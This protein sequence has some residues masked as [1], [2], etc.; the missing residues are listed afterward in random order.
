MVGTSVNCRT[1]SNSCPSQ[2]NQL[3]TVLYIHLQRLV[4]REVCKLATFFLT[5]V[6]LNKLICHAHLSFSANQFTWPRLLVQIQ[7]LNGKQCRSRSVGFFRSQLIWIC[8]VC[9]G[10]VYLGSAGQG[11][12]EKSIIIFHTSRKIMF[13]SH[14][15]CLS[16]AILIWRNKKVFIWLPYRQ[17]RGWGWGG[18][19]GVWV[20]G[21]CVWGGGGGESRYEISIFL[22]SP[23]KHMMCV[24]IR[25]ASWRNF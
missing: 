19:E 13:I 5:L 4:S 11:L 3:I 18:G 21:R 17:I 6:M 20:G 1:V 9:K 14:Y 2:L 25:S 15:N 22:M 8:T 12:I 23:W 16:E 24:L 7:I 10:S